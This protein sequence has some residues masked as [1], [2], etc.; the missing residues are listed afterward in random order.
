MKRTS[1]IWFVEEQFKLPTSICWESEA[2]Q[3]L[4]K[5]Y[6]KLKMKVKGYEVLSRVIQQENDRLK[7]QSLNIQREMDDVQAL[8]KNMYR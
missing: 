3:Q 6:K 7:T 5:K 1:E 4:K 2:Y 8:N